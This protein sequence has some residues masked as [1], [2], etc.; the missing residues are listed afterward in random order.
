MKEKIYH[1]LNSDKTVFRFISLIII[2]NIVALIFESYDY[3]EA[4][5][6]HAFHIFETFSIV[7]FSIEY[8]ARVYVADMHGSTRWKFISSFYGIVDLLA[9]LPFF[10]P[11]FFKL[12]MRVLRALRLFRFIRIFKL[13][14]FNNS[15][16]AIIDVCS[17]TKNEMLMTLFLACVL[18]LISSTLMYY[19]ESD[20]QPDKFK[21]IPHSLW[22]AISTLT[23]VGYGDVVPITPLG[24]ILSSIIAIIGIAFVALPTGILSSAFMEQIKKNRQMVCPHCGKSAD[25]EHQAD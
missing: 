24:K 10:L 3:I 21:S 13:G 5:Y 14:R 19:V 2:L 9:V 23:T 20:V 12:D 8:L 15:F 1:L 17:S 6:G 16:K 25:H 22:W 4:Q 11:F 7:I 18:L